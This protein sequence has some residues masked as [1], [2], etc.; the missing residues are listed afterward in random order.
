MARDDVLRARLESGS[1]DL[2]V[3]LYLYPTEDGGK[4]MPI[5]LGYSG[6]FQAKRDVAQGWDGYPL[7]REPMMPGEQRRVG[8]FLLMG[9]EAAA[10]LSRSSIIYLWEGRIVGEATIVR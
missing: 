7:L 6:V 1:P 9:R 2:T 10:E 3:D 4:S 8:L 5:T